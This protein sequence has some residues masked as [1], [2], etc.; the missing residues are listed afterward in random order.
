MSEVPE[1]WNSAFAGMMPRTIISITKA[2][3]VRLPG[4]ADIVYL[5]TTL[6]GACH[7]YEPGQTF[8]CE[9]ARGLGPHYV[10][11]AFGLTA[12]VLS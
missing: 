7:P 5:H 12:E 9:V 1:S 11:M 10:M 6:P 8:K 2:T 3:V 4:G